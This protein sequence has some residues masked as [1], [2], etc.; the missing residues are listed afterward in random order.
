MVSR[1][2]LRLLAGQ[3]LKQRVDSKFD[4]SMSVNE[5]LEEI[6]LQRI[7]LEL[8]EQEIFNLQNKIDNLLEY[9]SENLNTTNADKLNN[10]NGKVDKNLVFSDYIYRRL[11]EESSDLYIISDCFGNIT[12]VG[13]NCLTITGYTPEEALHIKIYDEIHPYDRERIKEVYKNSFHNPGKPVITMGRFKHKNGDWVWLELTVTNQI[14]DEEIQGIVTNARN[15]TQRLNAE[16]KAEEAEKLYKMLFEFMPVGI[17]IYEKQN[18]FPVNFNQV[19]HKQLGYSQAEYASKSIRDI[20]AFGVERDFEQNINL[21]LANGYNEF[22]TLLLKKDGTSLPTFVKVQVIKIKG[23]ELLLCIFQDLTEIKKTQQAAIYG[24]IK[25]RKLIENAFDGVYI[26]K[27]DKY[28][29]ANKSFSDIVEYSLTELTDEN[30]DSKLLLTEDSKS[31]VNERFS[32]RASGQQIENSFEMTMLTKNSQIRHVEVSTEDIEIDGELN[33]IGIVRDIS[34]RKH[35]IEQIRK[36]K[37]AAEK[38][39]EISNTIFNN[40]GH[41]LRTPLNGIIGFAK[42]MQSEISNSEQKEMLKM[43]EF[44]G[45]RLRKTLSALLILAEIDSDKYNLSLEATNL[46]SFISMYDSTTIE[47][48]HDKPIEFELIIQEELIIVNIDEYLL[49]QAIYELLENSYKFTDCGKV[50]LKVYTEISGNER[51]AVIEIEDTGI[52]IQEDKI[53]LIF[54]PFRQGSEGVSRQF[55]GMGLG[56]S[57]VKRVTEKLNGQLELISNPD[58]GTRVRLL[59]DCLY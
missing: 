26:M 56:L 33:I 48:L 47:L 24:E 13:N 38:S 21:T 40:L 29:Y 35:A 59:F 9:N 1:D 55:E 44:S 25:F 36:A 31:L 7:E 54:E 53:N 15:I 11:I 39:A 5:I 30:F 49:H 42:V 50:S 16:E 14:R 12:F 18:Y 51:K 10:E 37:E 4:L 22:E 3:L 32:K 28:V 27:G 52:G 45:E 57:I 8:R 34:E 19:S 6:C 58:Q 41:E 46:N 43:I 23:E 2:E 20:Y 17:V